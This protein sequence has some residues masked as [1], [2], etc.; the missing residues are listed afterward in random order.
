MS[1]IGTLIKEA[2]KKTTKVGSEH[3][4]KSDCGCRVHI[5]RFGPGGTLVKSEPCTEHALDPNRKR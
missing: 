2:E 1:P 5:S 4:A 3:T